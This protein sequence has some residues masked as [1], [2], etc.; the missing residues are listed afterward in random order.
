V[1]K[2]FDELQDKF[3]ELLENI[4]K[5]INELLTLLS[6][7]TPATPEQI[8][9]IVKD[10]NGFE[11][12]VAQLSGQVAA[13]CDKVDFQGAVSAINLAQKFN[14]GCN[15]QLIVDAA[16]QS[17]AGDC[18]EMEKQAK[19]LD[20]ILDSVKKIA[21]SLSTKDP[22]NNQEVLL[23]LHQLEDAIDQLKKKGPSAQSTH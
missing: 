20:G 18:R 7:K 11:S 8:A 16:K 10:I 3:E 12:Q 1:K 15:T 2:E 5:L 21:E 13:L 4:K 19:T 17:A 6:S 14:P 22:A 9:Q 23:I